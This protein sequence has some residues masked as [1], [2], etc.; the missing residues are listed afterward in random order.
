[1]VGK[2]PDCNCGVREELCSHLIAN[3][4]VAWQDLAMVEDKVIRSLITCMCF[5]QISS[6]ISL[7]R[8]ARYIK[9]KIIIKVQFFS[10]SGSVNAVHALETIFGPHQMS[11]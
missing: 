2:S 9:K 4:G 5:S 10:V 8:Q 11:H 1:M 6:K 3:L 7:H